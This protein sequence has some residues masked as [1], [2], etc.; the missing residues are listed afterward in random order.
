MCCLDAAR[1]WLDDAACS[2]DTGAARAPR[3]PR[4]ISPA[5]TPRAAARRETRKTCYK[6]RRLVQLVSFQVSMNKRMIGLNGRPDPPAT[7]TAYSKPTPHLCS[8]HAHTVRVSG[9][10]PAYPHT[11]TH[12][13]HRC[14]YESEIAL[15]IARELTHQTLMNHVEIM[16]SDFTTQMRIHARREFSMT[17]MTSCH[18]PL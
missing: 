13:D 2:Q 12:R 6:L 14:A 3:A 17:S 9:T 8:T 5:C 16:P 18:P 1:R 11:H 7:G 10:H 15:F 4:H